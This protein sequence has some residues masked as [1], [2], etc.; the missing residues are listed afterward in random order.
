MAAPL[1]GQAHAATAPLRLAAAWDGEDGRHYIGVLT[2]D[3]R[4]RSR[5]AVHDTLEVPTRA[6]AVL[7]CAGGD[8]VAVARRPGAWMVR[9]RPGQPASSAQ[10]RWSEPDRSF[11][12]H[13]VHDGAGALLCTE[14]DAASGAGLLVRRD[15]QR[16]HVLDEWP[17]HGIDAHAVLRLPDGG[18]LVANGGVPTRPESGRTKRNL[19]AMDSSLA[20]LDA[21]GELAGTWWLADRRLS[22]RHLALHADGTVGVAMQAE[23][24]DPSAR[25]DAPLLALWDGHTLRTAEAAPLAGYAGDIVARPEGFIV[26]ATRAGAV[27]QYD[28]QGRIVVQHRVT[29]ACALAPLGATGWLAAGRDAVL[30]RRNDATRGAGIVGGVRIDNHWSLLPGAA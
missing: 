18:W 6:H 12:G 3:A 20:R 19:A 22:L 23:H 28:L 1:C 11:N 27:V 30:Q 17:T 26:A 4:S 10:W 15:A 16:L 21:R 13:V 8:L 5:V 14:T 7:A 25:S 9:W 29:E 2:L 24:D